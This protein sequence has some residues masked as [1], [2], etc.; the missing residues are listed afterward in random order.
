M[1]EIEAINQLRRVSED[2]TKALNLVIESVGGIANCME[3]LL[4]RIQKLEG[5]TDSND[6]EGK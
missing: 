5:K 2:T 4:K 6:Q 3:F 1:T